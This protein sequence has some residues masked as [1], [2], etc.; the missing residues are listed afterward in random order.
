MPRPRLTV[1]TYR[2]HANG[3]AVVSVYRADGSRTEILLPGKFGSAESKQEYE[4]VLAQLR[5][6]NGS[7]PQAKH[8]TDITIVELVERFMEHARGYYVDPVTRNPTSEILALV[9]AFRPLVRICG[10]EPAASFGPLALQAVRNAM[11][12]GS[13]I[14]DDE[15]I[16]RTRKGRKIGLAR[17]TCNDNIARIKLLFRWSASMELIPASVAHALATVAGLRRGRSGAR[18]TEPVKPISSAIIDDTIP[19]LPP[20]VCDMVQILLFTG[21]RC[22]ELC[23]MR[24]ADLDMTGEIW[25]YRPERHKGLWRGRERVIAIGPRAQA[26]IR[27]YLTPHIDAYMFTPA[28]QDEMIH[29][30]RRA[31]RRTPL[32]PSHAKRLAAK[33]KANGKRRPGERFAVAAINRAVRRACERANI[34]RW[35]VHQLRHSASLTFARELGLEAARAALGHASVDMSA[36]YAGHDIEAAK[37]VAAHV[38]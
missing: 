38:G 30:A 16:E 34:P 26:I 1:P 10:S 27:H 5:A 2:R 28:A 21:M 22:G 36:M 17:T 35:H 32:Y 8:A 11:L 15:R 18:E 24:A 9:A 3:Q 23:V 19:H 7:L 37:K 33:R 20:M 6:N 12:T 29:A 4:R 13:W 14:G 31:E 25:L